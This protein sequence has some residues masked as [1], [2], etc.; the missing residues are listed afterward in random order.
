MAFNGWPA[1]AVEFYTGLEADNSKSY[2]TE[3]RAMY[4]QAVKGPMNELS[5]AIEDEFGP[6][7]IFRPYRD[8]RFSK[9]RSPYKTNIGAVTEGEGGEIYYVQLSSE[10]LLVGTG[11]FHMATDQL[12]RHRA[13]LDDEEL[14][15]YV[16]ALVEKLES[17]G[18]G[19]GS[20]G[21]LKTAPRGYRRDHPRVRLL[22]MKGLTAWRTFEP[23]P[24]FSTPAALDRVTKT[25]RGGAALNKWLCTHVGTS[26]LAPPEAEA[27]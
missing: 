13:A 22:R 8:V 24:W 10:G 7:R 26:R 1:E 5:A 23:A 17:A 20:I 18:Y 4:E 12:E 9:D 6:L 19:I 3:H 2:W 11:F 16:E 21:E 27:W 25:W 14:G 15:R